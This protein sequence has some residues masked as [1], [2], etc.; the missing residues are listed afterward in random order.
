MSEVHDQVLVLIPTFGDTSHLADLV[1]EVRGLGPRYEVLIVDDGSPVAVA[2]ASLP[3]ALV[4]RLP[5]NMGL[6]VATHVAFDYAARFGHGYLIRIDGDAQHPPANIPRVLSALEDGADL[7]VGQRIRQR[8]R[9]SARFFLS[10]TTKAYMALVSRLVGG[11]Q[12]PTDVTS[13]FLGFG[14]RALSL[15]NQ[16]ELERYPEPQICILA[17][18]KGLNIRKV[19]FDPRP[20]TSGSSTITWLRGFQIIYRFNILVLREILQGGARS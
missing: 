9:A 10:E 5:D 20:R 18:R 3:Q 19:S 12:V 15:L 7:V 1:A 11:R 2:H 14:T 16:C 17:A 4:V 13:G 8:F 6:G